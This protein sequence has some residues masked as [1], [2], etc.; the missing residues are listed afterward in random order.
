[1]SPT[2]KYGCCSS[3]AAATEV[4]KCCE[5]KIPH[6]YGCIDGPGKKQFKDL[7][8]DVKSS[9]ICPL[10]VVKRPKSDVYE[11]H[12]TLRKKDAV[13]THTSLNDFRSMIRE[14]V[15]TLLDE[16]RANILRQFDLQSTEVLNRLSRVDDALSNLQVKYE[17]VKKDLSDKTNTI[18]ILES[19]NQDLK[20]TIMDLSSRLSRIDQY[21]RSSNIE[22]QCIPEFKSED[23]NSTVKQLANTINYNLNEADIHICKRTS[24]LSKENK[25]PRSVFV[26][27][28]CPRV[29]D[30]FLA[31]TITFNKRVTSKADKL[32]SSH[33]G[34]AGE[35][36][37]IYVC[38]HL[39]PAMKNVHAAARAKAKDLNYKFVWVKGGNVYMRKT[40]SSEYKLIKSVES[41]SLLE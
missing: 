35:R 11:H 19:E 22:I 8:A 30:E 4:L 29:R 17:E 34:I 18:T 16:F 6:H 28:S 21:S 2:H 13:I 27:F 40:E 3:R 33:L 31:A 32:N 14:E 38:E 5:C 15:S 20:S 10:C 1:M 37:P 23:L 41:L 25:R 9:W 12:V 7:S 26:K 39:T 24:K 36:R